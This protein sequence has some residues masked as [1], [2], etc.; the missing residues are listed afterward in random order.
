M[1]DPVNQE[2]ATQET[3][4]LRLDADGIPLLDEVLEEPAAPQAP[5]AMPPGADLERLAGEIAGRVAAE[6]AREFEAVLRQ[7]LE[8]ELRDRLRSIAP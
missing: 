4:P 5:A 7:R 6:M 1:S 2:T 8:Q 3:A